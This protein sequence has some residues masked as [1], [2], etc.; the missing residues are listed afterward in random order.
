MCYM[1]HHPLAP[2]RRRP[3]GPQLPHPHPY[4]SFPSTKEILH[5]TFST[6]QTQDILSSSLVLSRLSPTPHRRPSLVWEIL[7]PLSST[8]ASSLLN[9][10]DIFSFLGHFH[11]SFL[12]MV[13]H[14]TLISD[15][16]LLQCLKR[17]SLVCFSPVSHHQVGFLEL[18]F[19][20]GGDQ[21]VSSQHG[22]LVH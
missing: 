5:N 7:A 22:Y 10:L 1:Q 15:F 9:N 18:V 6:L 2:R 12:P 20:E 13:A 14:S 8:V 3:R 4:P 16:Y 17:C 21:G 19:E 11:P